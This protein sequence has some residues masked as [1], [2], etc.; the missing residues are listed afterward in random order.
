MAFYKWAGYD[1]EIKYREGVIEVETIEAAA[2]HLAYNRIEPRL[3]KE[4]EYDE[5]RHAK[6]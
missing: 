5:Y 1:S 6:S 3:L 2:Y 4:I